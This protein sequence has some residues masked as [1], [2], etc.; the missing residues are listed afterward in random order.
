MAKVK[1]IYVFGS[2]S[3]NVFHSPQLGHLPYH[4]GDSKPHSLQTYI[5]LTFAVNNEAKSNRINLVIAASYQTCVYA[6]Y[7]DKIV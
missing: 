3:F 6:W 7:P 2:S 1:S 4:F 5:D